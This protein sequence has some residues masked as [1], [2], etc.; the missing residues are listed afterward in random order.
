MNLPMAYK[1]SLK[2]NLRI[3][4]GSCISFGMKAFFR[5]SLQ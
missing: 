3:C 1:Q 2:G 5:K 4:A